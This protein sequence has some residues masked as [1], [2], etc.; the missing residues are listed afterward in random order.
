MVRSRGAWAHPERSTHACGKGIR[1]AFRTAATGWPASPRAAGGTGRSTAAARSGAAAGPARTGRAAGS[2]RSPSSPS[3][4][5]SSR[6]TP[7]SSSSASGSPAQPHSTVRSLWSA[8]K[9]DAVVDAVA[10]AVGHLQDVPALAVGVVDERRRRPPS[11]AAASE[12]SWTS[13]I[14]WSCSSTPSKT[15]RKPAGTAPSG[16]TVTAACRWSGSRHTCTMPGPCGPSR[17][18]VC[19]TTSQ[20]SAS[21]TT[22]AATSRRA[23]VPSGKSQSGRSPATGL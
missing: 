13:E 4:A 2:A 7:A 15:W 3:R 18:M 23:R 19:G 9:R 11:G 6:S 20:P 17:R 5:S 21:E 10:V 14:G 12:S 16:T 22:Y 8:W 1:A